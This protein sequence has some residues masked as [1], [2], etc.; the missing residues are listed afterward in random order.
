MKFL[1]FFSVLVLGDVQQAYFINNPYSV[2]SWTVN[3]TV[4]I[5]FSIQDSVVTNGVR[6]IIVDLMFGPSLNANAILNIVSGLDPKLRS[7]YFT[8]PDTLGTSDGYFLRVTG[9]QDVP[10]FGYSARFTINGKPG[11]PPP[12]IPSGKRIS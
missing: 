9:A 1:Y 10:V 12:V 7:I 6:F 4:S 11:V 2:T 5:E 3:T 8:I